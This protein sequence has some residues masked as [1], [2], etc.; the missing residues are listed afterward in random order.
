MF[1]GMFD[2]LSF[3]T[4][5]GHPK[6]DVIVLNST[7]LISQTKD[8]LGQYSSVSCY[9]DNDPTGTKCVDKIREYIGG[10]KVI[11]CSCTYRPHNDY[12]EYHCYLLEQ[13]QKKNKS[14]H[15]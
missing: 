5:H 1:E 6:A 13:D 7:S 2:F 14:L 8:L 9:F 4:L 10:D 15:L 12:N 11:D 3:V